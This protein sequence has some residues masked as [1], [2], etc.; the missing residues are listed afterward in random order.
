M[1]LIKLNSHQNGVLL[2]IYNNNKLNNFENI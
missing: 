2:I 1:G